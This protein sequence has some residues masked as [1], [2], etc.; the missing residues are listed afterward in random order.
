MTQHGT[1]S[2]A[3]ADFA[4]APL[5]PASFLDRAARVFAGRTALVDGDRTFTYAEFAARAE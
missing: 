1:D 2:P 5:T 3:V 4:F